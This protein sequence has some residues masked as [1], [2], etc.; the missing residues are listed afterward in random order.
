MDACNRP[1]K[2]W[3]AHLR[4]HPMPE[5]LDEECMEALGS[6]EAQYGDIESYGAGLEIRLGEEKRFADYILLVDS[7]R[8]PFIGQIWYE[9]DYDTFLK[10]SKNGGQIVPCLF[11]NIDTSGADSEKAFWDAVLPAFLGTER[12]LRL[13]EPLDALLVKL[14][15]G[16]RVKQIGTM[17]GRSELD[18]M[19]LAIEYPDWDSLVANLAVL[20]W[21]GDTEAF[22]EATE[23]WKET[24][25]IAVD[26]DLG[27][28]GILPKIG[29]ETFPRWRNPI[30][31]DKFISRLETA[32]LCLPP[33]AEALRR[34]IRLHP[35]GDPFTQTLVNYFKLVYREGRIAEAKAYLEASPFMRHI[36]FERFSQPLRI[37]MELSGAKGAMDIDI[38][39]QRIGECA[40]AS[41]KGE[42]ACPVGKDTDG[43]WDLPL[44]NI[45]FYG[46]E[47]YGALDR[48]LRA[49]REKGIRAEVVLKEKVGKKRLLEMIEAGVY[50]FLVELNGGDGGGLFTLR[51]L[52]RLKAPWVR[53]RWALQ[54]GNAG[55]LEKAIRLASRLGA[56]EF[57]VTGMRPGESRPDF[58]E[59][60]K[61][62]EILK[63]LLET[64]EEEAPKAETPEEEA[65]EEGMP[66]QKAMMITVESCF[67]QL[68]AY[69]GGENSR[70]NPNRGIGSG[71]EA[72]RSF[73]ALRAAGTLSPCLFLEGGETWE[74]LWEYW[75][76]SP[77][78]GPFREESMPEAC[79]GCCYI[80]RCRPCPAGKEKSRCPGFSPKKMSP[81]FASGGRTDHTL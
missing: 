79:E 34:W 15:D 25:R 45:R 20:G 21:P 44:G 23:P 59:I 66:A 22:R 77:S 4:R 1:V 46:C 56:S 36:Y 57:I 81:T 12:A 50:S 64:P 19:R 78:L 26:L 80:R 63:P 24:A 55:R 71:C 41:G 35:E 47:G 37:D 72:G 28:A 17:S 14:P 75:E 16:T 10:A 31:A 40:A 62:A 74:S 43:G 58:E 13:R 52:C 8:F 51:N 33:K 67:S 6:V 7:D 29:L 27:Q 18:I 42:E 76:K 49:C 48:L 73:M 70:K 3:L 5:F 68:R 54:N 9:I 32:G 53:G 61:A 69:M 39:L 30:L 60:Q 11:A 65:S 38:A 2:F